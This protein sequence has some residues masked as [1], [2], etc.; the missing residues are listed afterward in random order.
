[1]T[2]QLEHP[3]L[4]STPMVQAIL[5]G[6][7][8][9]TRRVVKPEPHPYGTEIIDSGRPFFKGKGRWHNRFLIS[10]NPKRY[11]I[12]SMHDCPF[13]KEGDLLWVRES[14][15]L[16]INHAAKQLVLSFDA[17]PRNGTN[18]IP[19]SEVKKELAASNH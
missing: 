5:A 14:H 19:V 17:S 13:G 18:F 9:Q 12:A 7:K 16:Y 15:K 4:M 10:E 8:T 2:I 1:M 11:E 3:I 6:T